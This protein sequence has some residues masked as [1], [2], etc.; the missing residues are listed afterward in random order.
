MEPLRDQDMVS[1]RAIGIK[2]SVMT[3]KR[4][5]CMWYPQLHLLWMIN[6]HAS[7]NT[8]DIMCLNI[9]TGLDCFASIQDI[10]LQLL[11]FENGHKGICTCARAI[12]LDR[13]SLRITQQAGLNVHDI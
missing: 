3:R 7:C 10:M 8:N 5:A 4:Q 9:K 1:V 2:E 11:F 12:D 6:Q 13:P